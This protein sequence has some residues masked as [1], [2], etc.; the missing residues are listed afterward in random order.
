MALKSFCI[1]PF[2][3]S[4]RTTLPRQL[5]QLN[6]VVSDKGLYLPYSCSGN[7]DY[8]AHATKRLRWER[9]IPRLTARSQSCHIPKGAMCW[10]NPPFLLPQHSSQED[11][12]LQIWF[13]GSQVSLAKGQHW[14][15]RTGKKVEAR[16]SLSLSAPWGISAA[17]TSNSCMAP[18]AIRRT[19]YGCWVTPLLA[20]VTPH[21]PLAPQPRGVA[22][23]CCYWLLGSYTDL[24]PYRA[25]T[26]C[27]TNS[28]P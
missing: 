26:T 2:L 25:F 15:R 14:Q 18:A 11:W 1:V 20:L 10:S 21:F 16:V 23:S 4:S 8:H 3:T 24:W 13:P 19:H 17:A 22:A 5:Q 6:T 7:H 28:L 9:W 27:L 12:S